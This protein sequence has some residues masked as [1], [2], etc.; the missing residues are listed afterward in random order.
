MAYDETIH[1]I[2]RFNDRELYDLPEIQSGE[3]DLP[4]KYLDGAI[5]L[6]KVQSSP[7]I[8]EFVSSSLRAGMLVVVKETTTT[9]A[10]STDGHE[11]AW[12][13]IHDLET[14]DG[15]YQV[16]CDHVAEFGPEALADEL[17]LS[18]SG[19]QQALRERAIIIQHK[20]SH[21][22]TLANAGRSY[23]GRRGVVRFMLDYSQKQPHNWLAN[24]KSDTGNIYGLAALFEISEARMRRTADLMALE[25]DIQI[26]GPDD[27]VIRPSQLAA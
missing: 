5:K 12:S 25:G 15:H 3:V 20:L 16:I 17:L 18:C 10:N 27:Q 4:Q 7:V 9:F 2:P 1:P 24:H 21:Q 6:D 22:E 11:V 14:G 23:G 8:D 26:N 13:Y 19:V